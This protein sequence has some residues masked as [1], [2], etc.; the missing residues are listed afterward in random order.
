MKMFRNQKGFTLIELVLIIVILGVMAAVAIPKFVS[1]QNDA[2]AATNIAYIGAVRSAVSIR[3][4]D[5]L[6]HGGTP[7]VIGSTAAE[8]PATAANL[9]GLVASSKPSSLTTTAGACGVG[10]WTGLQPGSP[11]ASGN[12]SITCGATSSD[13]ISVGGP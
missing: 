6:L 1:L 4:A 9:E 10:L 12:W 5:Q 13:P 11:P 2:T 7:D 8:A 3:F